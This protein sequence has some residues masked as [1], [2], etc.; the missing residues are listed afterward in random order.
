V[1]GFFANFVIGGLTGVMLASVTIDTQLHDTFF[2]VA[3]LHYVLI[4]GA[5]FPLFGAFYYWFPKWTGRMLNSTLG[6]WNFWLM[7]VGF[8][9]TF[10]PM[11]H[12]GL[13]GM[14][15]RIYTYVPETGWGPMNHLASLGA[16]L[17]AVSV[18]VF[19][20]NVLHSRK[21]GTIAGNNPWGAGT[22]EWATSS[23]PPPYN[24]AY[25]PTC[26]GR[27]PLWE[28][29]PDSPVITGLS[30]DHR[31]VLIT[32]TLDAAP[33]HRYALPSESIVPFLLACSIAFLLLAG[34][35]F[36]PKY[37]LYGAAAATLVL[38]AWFWGSR[39]LKYQAPNRRRR[40]VTSHE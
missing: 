11:H 29:E 5:V 14:S 10:W 3:H 12:L 32:T 22:F 40:S 23:P 27:E 26:Q 9:L 7:F 21:R 24:F 13:H 18:L 36:D 4:G 15:R 34:G 33:D 2:V 19:V 30:T 8:N 16:V 38:F 6:H 39:W 31:E 17:M 1:L 25:P 37:A 28:N 20:Y 35:I